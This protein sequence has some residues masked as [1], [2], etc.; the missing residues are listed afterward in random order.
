VS[1]R[2]PPGKL[3]F[4]FVDY[5]AITV[6]QQYNAASPLTAA[7]KPTLSA[8]AAVNGY[9]VGS[10]QIVRDSTLALT[11]LSTSG[12][13]AQK[14]LFYADQDVWVY[15]YNPKT[16]LQ[17]PVFISAGEF[18]IFN[19]RCTEIHVYYDSAPGTLSVWFEG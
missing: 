18:Y 8:G 13:E 12:F 9:I 6:N 11:Y 5:A 17:G 10:N 1:S 3:T 7:A 15:F 2:L 4:D 14:E 19:T 16:G